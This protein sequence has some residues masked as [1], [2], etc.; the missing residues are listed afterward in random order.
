MAELLKNA[1][2]GKSVRSRPAEFS[3]DGEAGQPNG[4][5]LLPALTIEDGVAVAVDEAFVQFL[6]S[7]GR[8]GLKHLALFIR[9]REIH[10]SISLSFW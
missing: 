2:G 10:Q 5:A 8:D 7:E 9:P 3:G 1:D 4:A 6:P